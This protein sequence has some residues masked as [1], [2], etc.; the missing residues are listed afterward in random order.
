MVHL[1]HAHVYIDKKMSVLR[2][3]DIFGAILFVHL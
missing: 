3:K 2:Q 1:L